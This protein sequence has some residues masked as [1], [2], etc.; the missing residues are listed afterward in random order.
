VAAYFGAF[1]KTALVDLQTHDE[2]LLNQLTL[3][4][5]TTMSYPAGALPGL[6]QG[7]V[8]K[9]GGLR[10][11]V[12]EILSVNDGSELRAKLTQLPKE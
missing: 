7:E 5:E 2:R 12:R 6:Q 10:Y 8:V 11:Q 4:A 1:S 9:V 3:S